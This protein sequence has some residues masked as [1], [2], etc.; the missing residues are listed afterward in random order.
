MLKDR[1]MRIV[2]SVIA[3]SLAILALGA[4]VDM[5]SSTAQAQRQ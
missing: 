4:V 2:L 1:F 3:V 5:M